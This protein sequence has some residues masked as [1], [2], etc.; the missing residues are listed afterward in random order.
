MRALATAIAAVAGAAEELPQ[1]SHVRDT[2]AY[3]RRHERPDVKP[4]LVRKERHRVH[5]KSQPLL[6][7]KLRNH[8]YKAVSYLKNRMGPLMAQLAKIHASS[9]VIDNMQLCLMTPY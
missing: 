9:S 4:Q 3:P 5:L 8:V 6:I 1:T 7:K 2:G